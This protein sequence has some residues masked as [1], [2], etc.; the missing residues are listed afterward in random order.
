M[1]KVIYN[2]LFDEN[3]VSKD[4][5]TA[6]AALKRS[7]P[8]L[9]GYRVLFQMLAETHPRISTQ[10]VTNTPPLYHEC[11]DL[12][13]FTNKFENYFLYESLDHRKYASRQKL[14]LYL[15]ALPQDF[16][17]ARTRINT[18]LYNTSRGSTIPP[19]LELSRL[20]V[21]IAKYMEE[22]GIPLLNA[23]NEVVHKIHKTEIQN[24][25]SESIK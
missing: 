17:K 6:R 3:N 15:K 5:Q 4:Y 10:D 22:A 18:I 14:V 25:P 23:S 19:E 16:D 20:P 8:T 13:D 24:Q 9:D 11:D 2:Y 12:D 21:T 7:A 1:S